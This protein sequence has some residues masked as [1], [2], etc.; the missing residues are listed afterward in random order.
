MTSV[1]RL[2]LV[3]DDPISSLALAHQLRKRGFEVQQLTEGR[4]VLD[5]LRVGGIDLVLL[6][7]V[8]PEVDGLEVLR[9]IRKEYSSLQMPV[10]MVTA[11]ADDADVIEALNLGA[12]DYLRKPANIHIAVARIQ[13]QLSLK[14]YY[15]SSLKENDLK[16]L[17]EIITTYNHEINNPLAAALG[18]LNI[19]LDKQNFELVTRAVGEMDRIR[20]IVKKISELTSR[21]ITREVYANGQKMI[22]LAKDVDP[23]ET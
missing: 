22:G 12:S 10:I 16:T 18:F 7:I 5:F 20:K 13:T 3:D 9:R 1:K 19:A 21:E 23:K 2:L 11:R 15:Y 17:T 14:E 4:Q 6:D 8:M